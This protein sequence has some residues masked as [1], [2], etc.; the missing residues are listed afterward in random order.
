MTAETI[1]ALAFPYVVVTMVLFATRVYEGRP[2][3]SDRQ[4]ARFRLAL[5][6]W[7]IA[8]PIWLLVKGVSE[9]VRLV[10]TAVN[11]DA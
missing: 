1:V 11:G 9:F 5:L 8:G 10:I 7:P 2:Y 6:V 3:W 4:L